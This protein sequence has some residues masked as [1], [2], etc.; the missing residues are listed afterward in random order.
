[1]NSSDKQTAPQTART[2]ES[3][4][5]QL[6]SISL[7]KGGGAIR[8]ISEK[9]SVNPVTGTGSMVIPI[10]TS[11]GRDGFGPQLSLTYDSGSGDGVFGIGWSLSIPS[12][13]RKTD[14]GLPRYFGSEEFDVFLLSGSEDLVPEYRKK[15]DGNWDLDGAGRFQFDDDDRD[16]Y[17]VRSYRPR[18]EKL[19]ARIERWARLVDGDTHWRSISKDNILSVYGRSLD[20]RIADP[21]DSTHVFSW[22][23]CES[24]D[25]KGNAVQ[26]TYW[27]EDDLDVDLFQA[28]ER[29]RVRTANLYPRSI[30]YGNQVPFLIDTSVTS[31]R[32]S[33]VPQP[34]LSK[35]AWMFEAVFDYGAGQY[36]DDPPD[37]DGRI[38]ANASIDVPAGGTWPVRLDPFS[39]YRST[40]EVRCYR[41][42]RRMQLRASGERAAWRASAVVRL[43]QRP[44]SN[45]W[46]RH[47]AQRCDASTCP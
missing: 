6:P 41:L 16:G 20:S 23:L 8:G 33:H 25:A 17:L 12:I 26:Y 30:C 44:P 19:F 9:F 13:T 7:P 21:A 34:D 37:A 31:A 43:R 29:N 27:R 2:T 35:A 1:M 39:S 32:V 38:F 3:S 42:C 46:C 40:F 47:C 14:K 15:I 5:A 22:L 10:E 18:T 36:Q 4:S 24:Y 45:S 28:N 11:P